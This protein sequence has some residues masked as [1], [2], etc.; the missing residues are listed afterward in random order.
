[1]SREVGEPLRNIRTYQV[2]SAVLFSPRLG[3]LLYSEAQEIVR[4]YQAIVAKRT[5]RLG[6]SADASVGVGGRKNDRLVG[7]VTVGT[8]LEYGVL[9]EI[10]PKTSGLPPLHGAPQSRHRAHRE[11]AEAVAIWKGVNRS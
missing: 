9:H 8:G 10:G 4:L 2:P 7:R 5:G 1:M 3:A 6:A 11:L